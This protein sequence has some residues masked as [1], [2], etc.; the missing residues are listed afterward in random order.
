MDVLDESS[1]DIAKYNNFIEKMFE[2]YEDSSYINYNSVSVWPYNYMI[3][4]LVK[5]LESKE[6]T[7]ANILLYRLTIYLLE[8]SYYDTRILWETLYKK[9]PQMVIKIISEINNHKSSQINGNIREILFNLVNC[10][11]GDEY[12]EEINKLYSANEFCKSEELS[13]T[14]TLSFENILKI[15]YGDKL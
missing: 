11:R 5:T 3:K 1:F 12:D 6:K 9:Y 8:L 10:S 14:E 13:G 15:I 2:P 4:Y 7:E